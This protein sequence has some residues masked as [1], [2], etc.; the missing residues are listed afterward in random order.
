MTSK[1]DKDEKRSRG[2]P[3]GFDREVAVHAA[4]R[5]FWDR[6][7]EGS[8]FDDLTSAMGINA[9]SFRNTFKTK[10]ALYREAVDVYVAEAGE[11]FSGVL[12]QE[13]DVKSAFARLF[14]ETAF[15]FTKDRLPAGC[16]ISLAATHTPPSLGP[17]KEMMA[18]HRA[19]AETAM[20][21]RL[22]Q[23]Q[24]DGQIG[25]DADI[26]ATAAFFNAMFRGMAVQ[27]R[28]GASRGLLRDV[29]KVALQAF[30]T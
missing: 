20:F 1:I 23:G 16:M 27:A 8:S 3:K 28:D 12:A 24:E 5:L 15:Q 13:K 17:L 9:S 2:R 14:E 7:Y 18:Q 22:K 21:S 11:W 29:A 26:H 6:G 25:A 4:M 10:E 30:P 19:S